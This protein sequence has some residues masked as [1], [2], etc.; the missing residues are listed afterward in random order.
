QVAE[1]RSILGSQAA[2]TSVAA[3]DSVAAHLSLDMPGR[4]RLVEVEGL[5]R[6]ALAAAEGE[7]RAVESCQAMMAIGIVARE[8]DLTESID[9]FNRMGVVAQAQRLAIWHLYARSGAA[10][11]TWLAEGDVD[12]LVTTSGDAVRAGVVNVSSSMD[13]VHTLHLVMCGEFDAAAGR[14]RGCLARVR[15]LHLE[16]VERYLLMTRAVLHA[17]QGNRPDMER[18][19][20]EFRER[21]GDRSRELTLVL[22]MARAFCALLE[23][24]TDLARQELDAVVASQRENPT[25]F[26]LAGK[27]GLLPLLISLDAKIGSP[28]HRECTELCSVAVAS[29]RWNRQFAELGH[30]VLLGREGRRAEAEAALGRARRAGEYYPMAWHLGLRLVAAPAHQDGWGE[31]ATWLRQAEEYF[32]AAPVPVLAGACRALLRQIGAGAPHRPSGTDAVPVWLRARGITLREYEVL[33][34]MVARY[35]NREIATR[36]H[37]SHRT[38]EKHVASLLAKADRPN[39]AALIAY[40]ASDGTAATPTHPRP[41]F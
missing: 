17:H 13:A 29:M 20:A 40:A 6:S 35:G 5:A 9:W 15:R 34:L 4:G 10:T 1:A 19:I 7:S 12:A 36:L 25:T 31:P 22:G 32:H 41:P 14:L 30:A 2:P 11:S 18:S 23:E 39:R 3:I 27:H 24:N 8:R 38:V 21:G 26:Y 16:P 33:E 37:I 28:E